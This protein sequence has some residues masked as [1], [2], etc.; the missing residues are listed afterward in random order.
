MRY[1]LI[2]VMIAVLFTAC[3][4]TT[5]N[6][7]GTV[8]NDG[9]H[10]VVLKEVIQANAYTYLRVTEGSQEFW[11]AVPKMEVANVGETYYHDGGM[12]MKN[13]ESKDLG[14]TFESVYF[15]KEV[16]KERQSSAQVANP[17]GAMGGDGMQGA[18]QGTTAGA[19]V[20]DQVADLVIEK[21]EGAVTIAEI[22]AN[23]ESYSGKT[24][25]VTGLVTKFSGAIMNKNWIHLQDGTAH[26]GL[27][28]LTITTDA[29]VKKGDTVTIEGKVTLNKDFGYGY[30]YAVLMEDAV[31]F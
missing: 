15:L 20:T 22:F 6:G 25:K 24:V 29:V 8:A 18:N 26:E 13:F 10:E 28:D 14:R 1:F 16:R 11:L 12:E 3:T 5:E 21:A 27:F 4:S 7:S 30:F 9:I 17:H 19:K 23:K 31:L 2:S